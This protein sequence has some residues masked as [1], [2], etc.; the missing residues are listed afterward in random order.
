MFNSCE[1]VQ[2]IKDYQ[3]KMESFSYCPTEQ[4]LDYCINFSCQDPLGCILHKD[5]K[6]FRGVYRKSK[7]SFIELYNT[8]ILQV[9]A[10][11][12]WLPHFNITHYYTE[13]Y[14][15]VL[16]I[17]KLDIISLQFWTFSMIKEEARLKLQI[18]D[19]LKEFGYTLVDGHSGNVTFKNGKP[20]FFDFGSFIK[21]IPSAA[22]DEI[23]TFNIIPLMELSLGDYKS[24]RFFGDSP[25]IPNV[26]TRESYEAKS[27]IKRFTNLKNWKIMK[28]C[29]KWKL[30]S[31]SDLDV[32]FPEN[33]YLKETQWKDYGYTELSK[34]EMD[35][36]FQKI[37]G[38][39]KKYSNN[40]KTFL[41]LAGN[42]GYFSYLIQKN[43]KLNR[44][45]SSDYDEMAIEKGIRLLKDYN[46]NFLWFNFMY[47]LSAVDSLKS[48]IVC[49]L[50]VTHHL[51]LSQH[52]NIDYMLNT[53]KKYV[54]K[55]LYIEFCPLGMYP[56]ENPNEKPV[57]PDW[58][59]TEWF[60]SYFKKYFKLLDKETIATVTI[61]GIEYP[62]RILF[63]G[64]I[65]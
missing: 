8:G 11:I 17:E 13:E 34:V 45:I 12:G 27:A 56:C 31:G 40:A 7:E 22:I 46:I 30:L 63:V 41:D 55:N 38:K 1:I 39:I 19:I 26:N 28:K 43:M 57:V 48:D 65:L 53:L 59:T 5:G 2:K 33:C 54:N 51:L 36:R 64:E 15:V 49:A 37:L 20:I 52:I 44:V 3:N 47:Q 10:E 16:E 21:G 50:A 6:I 42:K 4:L 35:E 18:L 32:L 60:E 62:H 58:Y 29:K 23:Y 24:A 14:P 61:N 25:R 9:F